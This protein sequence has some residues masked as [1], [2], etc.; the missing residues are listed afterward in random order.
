MLRFFLFFCISGLINGETCSYQEIEDK[1][2]AIMDKFEAIDVK[3][4]SVKKEIKE[5]I[6]EE[7]A[8]LKTGL[9][10]A[11]TRAVRDLPF[12]TICAF[13]QKI[14]CATPSTTLT[15]DRIISEFNNADRPNGGDGDLDLSTGVF[16]CLYAGHYTIA[17]SASAEA[18]PGEEVVFS[19]FRNGASVGAE[20][21]WKSVASTAG[22]SQRSFD[23]GSRTVVSRQYCA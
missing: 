16:T 11:V 6:E 13:K 21:L 15:Y 3:I 19:I 18:D 22:S 8:G 17:V 4:D 20:G 7:V 12:V 1:L 14:C 5:D 10:T 9:A 23:Q 2:A